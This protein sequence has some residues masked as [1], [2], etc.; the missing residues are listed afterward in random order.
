MDQYC[1]GINML[2]PH[3]V[4]Y[5]N[6]KVTYKPELSHRN[7]LYADSLQVF[8]RFLSRLNV[9]LQKNGRHVADIAIVYP[10]SALQSEHTFDGPDGPSNTDP[11]DPT[12]AYYKKATAQID[13]IDVSNWLTNLVGKD[14]TFLHPEVLDQQ[15]TAEKG[16]LHL[17]NKLN[18]EDFKVI[19]VPSCSTISVSNLEKIVGFYNAGGKVIFTTRLPIKSVETGQD[20][21]I[22]GLINSIFPKGEER[23][24]SVLSNNKGGKVCFIN[25]PNGQNLREALQQMEN[26]FDVDYPVNEELRYIHK[27]V[28]NLNMYYFANIG[29][30][31]ANTR[32]I[33]RGNMNLESWDPHTGERQRVTTKIINGNPLD[34]P[35]T[36]VDLNLKPFQSI[37]YV[38]VKN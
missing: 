11:L 24:G 12:T 18:W 31:K 28:N 4:W 13:Y 17:Q 38:E 5:D 32:V 16:T 15:C 30:L 10:I 7:P 34:L 14:F 33:L 8:T 1:K 6:T 26:T 25:H 23:A 20:T 29:G 9:M 2:I 21:K 27:V 35:K 37:F 19:I 3:A 22:S 36:L